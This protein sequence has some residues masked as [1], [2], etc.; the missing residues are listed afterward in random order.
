MR[1]WAETLNRHYG[2]NFTIAASTIGALSYYTDA[3]VID[4]IGLTD[5]YIPRHPEQVQGI[6]SGWRE[7]KFNTQ[8]L[9]DQDPDFILFST[10]AEPTA[11]AEKALFLNSKF[12]RNYYSTYFPR[13]RMFYSIFKR[14]GIYTEKNEVFKDPEFVNLYTEAFNLEQYGRYQEAVETLNRV[15][16]IGP[17]DFAWAYELL[18]EVFYYIKDYPLSEKYLT[19]AIQMDEYCLKAY[20]YLFQI[21]SQQ[22]KYSDSQRMMDKFF[23]YNPPIEL[24]VQPRF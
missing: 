22:K 3:R 8:Y 17:K 21:Y 23:Q 24:G 19:Q 12:R 18:G 9:L 2:A 11:P 15:I 7:R 14:K 4:M 10:E 13:G 5:K 20:F 16:E 1:F 6:I